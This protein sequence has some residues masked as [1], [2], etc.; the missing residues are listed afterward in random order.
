MGTQ[1]VTGKFITFEGGE[2][3]GK[4]TQ[5]RRLAARLETLGHNVVQTREPGGSPGAEEIRSLLVNG[6]GDRW[7]VMTE[8][9]LHFAARADHLA[10]VIRPALANGT[11]VLCDRFSDSSIAYQGY[12]Q[13]LDLDAIS[14]LSTLVI[15]DTQPDL[16]YILDLPVDKGLARAQARGEGEDR[17]EK[18]GHSFHEK[19]RQAFLDIAEREPGRCALIDATASMDEVAEAIWR[20]A[21]TRFDL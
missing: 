16:T 19:L 13:G 8:A 9:L 7:T 12:G 4:S 10:Q 3:A 20:K 21:A 2:G 5:V 14:T 18:M 15:G 6:A 1:N 11:W 17:Y